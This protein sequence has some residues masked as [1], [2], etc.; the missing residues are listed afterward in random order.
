MKL[1]IFNLSRLVLM[2]VALVPSASCFAQFSGAGSGTKMDPYLIE[3]AKQLDE[4]RETPTSSFK[5]IND[6]DLTEFIAQHYP[7]HGWLA[8][9]FTG[10]FDGNGKSITGLTIDDNGGN[11]LFNIIYPKQHVTIKNL[12][13][14]GNVT[15]GDGVGG[16]I[17]IIN[18]TYFSIE[19]CHFS[20]SV[21]GS[22]NVGGIIGKCNCS[23]HF[24]VSK[25]SNKGSVK[26]RKNGLRIGRIG[27]IVGYMR[28]EG[29]IYD[30]SF[31]GNIVSSTYTGSG[32]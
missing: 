27:G 29:N 25:C 7:K 6:I 32:V 18:A 12:T 28:G 5:L 13:V 22:A 16:I 19:N 20:G 15:G 24:N 4:V 26:E 9:N 8:I 17:G 11:G 30:S 31:S 14:K 2:C 21:E 23:G 3:N 10:N 1:R